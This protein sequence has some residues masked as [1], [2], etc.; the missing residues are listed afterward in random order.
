MK[1]NIYRRILHSIDREIKNAVNE[2]FNAS[3]LYF[4]D[5]DD[6]YN[7]DYNANIFDKDVIDY[8]AIYNKILY[9]E[10]SLTEDDL[11]LL[12]VCNS[13]VD[14]YDVEDLIKIINFYVTSNEK[15]YCNKSLN[16][17]N[18][19]KITNMSRLFYYSE[20][21][22]D[23]SNWDVSNVTDMSYMF[24]KSKFN[25]DISKWNVFNVKTME[26]MFYESNFNMELSDW[27]V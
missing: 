7:Y 12:D 14:V 23:I 3:D 15:K 27:N 19:S 21:N 10:E 18:V 8:D 24:Y 5:D 25:N 6:D 16:W 22:G 13:V 9:D 1:N 20:Y 4:G 26:Y 11:N 2:Q 17:L